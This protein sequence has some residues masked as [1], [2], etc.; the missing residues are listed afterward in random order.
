MVVP[1]GRRFLMSEVPPYTWIGCPYT[2]ASAGTTHIGR[3]S[4]SEGL[5]RCNTI[6]LH[7]FE[8]LPH[9]SHP[10]TAQNRTRTSQLTLFCP[11]P[12]CWPLARGEPIHPQ[13]SVFYCRATSASTA[14]CTSM[15]MC[16]PAHTPPF[17][18]SP[19]THQPPIPSSPE[20]CG[21]D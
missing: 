13:R 1:G 12:L 19:T 15:R 18:A 17:F 20:R 2:F 7:L 4:K 6:P 16:C 9:I 14:P 5:L 10:C 21:R 8:P 11:P 3:V